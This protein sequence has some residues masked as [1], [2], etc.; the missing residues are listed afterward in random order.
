[1]ASWKAI[2]IHGSQYDYSKVEY[3]NN[4]TKVCIICPEHGEFWQTPHNHLTAKSKCPICAINERKN[5]RKLGL[6][7]FIKRTNEIN[8]NKYDYSK[9]EYKNN[10]TKVCII[11]PEHGEFWQTPSSH[12][13]QHAQCPK[14][15]K[16]YMDEEYFIEC[17]KK[18]H[19]NKY[20]YS[21]VVYQYTHEKVCIICPEHG[22][23]WQTP[24]HHLRGV[25][26][27]KCSN[28]KKL[29]TEEFIEKA[30]LVHGN[31]YDYAKVEYINNHTKVLI[32]CPKHG[33]FSQIPNSHL[34]G[35]G[36]PKCKMSKLERD[37]MMIL[38][39]NHIEYIHQYRNLEILGKQSLD[40]Y[41]PKFN[42]AI[43]CQGEQ[44]FKPIQYRSEQMMNGTTKEKRLLENK[45]RDTKKKEKCKQNNI[46]L[47]YYLPK[48]D[49]KYLNINDEYFVNEEGLLSIL[50]M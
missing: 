3:S 28:N 22:E 39:K 34:N 50:S 16:D 20:D 42:I 49:V 4:H 21:K 6:E 9:V 18:I 46:R 43:E 2:D 17:A 23:F 35:R 5:K 19:N 13:Y 27:P 8:G 25:G 15:S 24:N 41:L 26:C 38:N 40:F 11:C 48:K 36:C 10:M 12:L 14:C 30:K 29:T 31:K 45:N 32:T 37:I 7:E 44:H 33:D 47:L 1:M